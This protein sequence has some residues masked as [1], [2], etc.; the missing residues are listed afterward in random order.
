MDLQHV[1]FGPR[2]GPG[3]DDL[4]ARLTR[5]N[6]QIQVQVDAL[7]AGRR[8][9][10][11]GHESLGYFAQRYGFRLVGA[12]IPSLTSE[13][14]SSAAG[15]Q[16]LKQLI[17]QNQVSVVFTELGTP[18]RT[19]EA[20]AREAKVKSVTLA[21]HNLPADGSYFT[22]ERDLSGAILGALK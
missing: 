13:A 3:K 21:T 20:L 17:A 12:V 14:E 18:P 7:P 22:F 2:P 19:L 16:A 5:L 6:A 10:V 4:D 8:K 11:T 15:L 1:A 9:L